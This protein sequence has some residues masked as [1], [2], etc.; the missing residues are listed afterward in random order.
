M[1]VGVRS[2]CCAFVEAIDESPASVPFG[3][4]K[5]A[6]SGVRAQTPNPRLT[7]SQPAHRP[8]DLSKP[9]KASAA[10]VAPVRSHS[11]TNDVGPAVD[12]PAQ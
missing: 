3:N 9:R 7:T 6:V 11:L 5:R 1:L 12:Q 8:L 2:R 4:T 10:A